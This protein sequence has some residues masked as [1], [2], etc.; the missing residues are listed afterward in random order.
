MPKCALGGQTDIQVV[1]NNIS[2]YCSKLSTKNEFLD[3]IS[4][5]LEH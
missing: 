2:S 4:T 1:V 5:Q 3:W